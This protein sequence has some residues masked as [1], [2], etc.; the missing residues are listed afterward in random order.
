MASVSHGP[1]SG[2]PW[3]A[4]VSGPHRKCSQ[5][6]DHHGDHRLRAAWVLAIISGLRRGELA[7]LKWNRLDLDKGIVFVHWQRTATST[8]VVE[9]EPKGKSRRPIALG[10]AVVAELDEHKAIQ[11]AEK[12]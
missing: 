6:L 4:K 7:G 11:H 5:F 1:H 10:P 12:A 9:K 2:R 8:G 3:A